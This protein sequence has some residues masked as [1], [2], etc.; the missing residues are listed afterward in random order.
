MQNI[1][2]ARK[3]R[4]KKIVHSIPEQSLPQGLK[5]SHVL[6]DKKAF[7]IKTQSHESHKFEVP[8]IS[9]WYF[10]LIGI[11]L[12]T[13]GLF[14]GMKISQKESSFAS[15]DL[16]SFKNISE[17]EFSSEKTRAEIIEPDS[18]EEN[19][20]LS[21]VPKNLQ[22]PPKLNQMNYIIQLGTFTPEEANKYAAS[23]IHERQE[24]QGRVF[25]TTTGKLYLGFYYDLKEAKNVLK[26]IRKFQGGIFQ[27]AEIKNIQF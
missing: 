23:L 9:F 12:F 3:F 21:Y 19:S 24:F 18:T 15:G 2:Y 8:T 6:R 27:D 17:T 4:K 7:K 20:F 25:R 26:K 10:L 16:Q 11:F 14:I 5:P 22:F 13:S 1:D